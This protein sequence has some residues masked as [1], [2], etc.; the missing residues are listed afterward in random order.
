M[1][2]P[3]AVKLFQLK[4]SLELVKFKLPVALVP[5]VPFMNV[6]CAGRVMLIDVTFPDAALLSLI[7]RLNVFGIVSFMLKDVGVMTWVANTIDASR[8]IADIN[9]KNFVFILSP[10]CL[11]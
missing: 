6:N 8:T 7:V 3:S 10:Y 2:N 5:F 1:L 11:R 4:V 9:N